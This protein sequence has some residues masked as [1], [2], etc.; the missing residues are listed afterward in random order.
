MTPG[1][2]NTSQWRESGHEDRNTNHPNPYY[3]DMRAVRL[4]SPPTP[5]VQRTACVHERGRRDPRVG[6]WRH[7]ERRKQS[8]T[9]QNDDSERSGGNRM[10][11]FTAY[12]SWPSPSEIDIHRFEADAVPRVGEE[13]C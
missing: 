1:F 9:C 13:L 6:V 2:H 3:E 7:R 5:S 12:P 4:Q 11:C 10:I 8:K